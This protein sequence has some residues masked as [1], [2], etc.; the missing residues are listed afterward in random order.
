AAEDALRAGDFAAGKSLL[1][2]VGETDPQMY[3][4]PFILGEAA[5]KQDKWDEASAE[6]RKCLGLNPHFD[7]A[8]L[9]LARALIFQGK[10]DEAKRWAQSAIQSNPD[11][12]RA[13]YQLGFID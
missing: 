8:M 12:Y 9:G 7:Q 1:S 11:D 10:L 4:V 13:W 2:Q 6:F 5:L 3:I